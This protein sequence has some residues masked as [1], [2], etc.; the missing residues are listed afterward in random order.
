MLKFLAVVIVT[1]LLYQMS[2]LDTVVSPSCLNTLTLV[3]AW[4]QEVWVKLL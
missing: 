4:S 2:H 3:L 1:L